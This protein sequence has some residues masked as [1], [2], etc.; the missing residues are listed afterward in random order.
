MNIIE[1]KIKNVLNIGAMDIKPDG[2]MIILSGKNGAG[3]SNVIR[4]LRMLLE[5]YKVDKPVKDGEKT[6]E[7]FG[8]VADDNGQPKY[9]VTRTMTEKT[10]R[11]VV[12]SADKTPY[13]SPATLLASLRG[14]LGFDP[15]AF[16]KMRPAEQR[17]L[18][19]KIVGVDL[20]EHDRM[21]RGIYDE[22]TANGREL[23]RMQGLR[24]SLPSGEGLPSEVVPIDKQEAAITELKRK[25]ENWILHQQ[26]GVTTQEK[27]D[28]L[29]TQL[30][31]LE[32]EI[33]A[34]IDQR[35]KLQEEFNDRNKV[36]ARHRQE[37]PKETPQ[38]DID[39]AYTALQE[40]IKS[41]AKIEA[42]AGAKN[43]DKQIAEQAEKIEDETK[44]IED[45]DSA[46]TTSL[47]QCELPVEGLEATDEGV[48]YNGIP[49]EQIETGMQIRISTML[50]MALNPKLKVL[51]IPDGDKLDKGNLKAIAEII[52]DEK[53]QV[54]VEKMID[55]DA[56][57]V[58]I[59]I[60]DGAI[61][62]VTELV[63]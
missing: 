6:G 34:A 9:H 17:A 14:D 4:C 10:E 2:P 39:K 27:Q 35:N 60:V 28:R 53:Y 44:T 40:T 59:H 56:Q 49:F 5:G 58:G 41:N 16:M 36:L 55:D 12:T 1:M 63:I 46:L 45:M 19:F 23:K 31:A 54:W 26:V 18:L 7:I 38:E 48:K 25:R 3:K 62:S 50:G 37:T 21:R 47:A 29:S 57:P 52:G 24:Q 33:D 20:A 13:A 22:R 42:M 30:A 61:E 32:D 8:I 15:M 11:L 51:C 43:L